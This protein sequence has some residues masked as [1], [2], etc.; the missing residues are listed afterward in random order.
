MPLPNAVAPFVETSSNM[1][2]FTGRPIIPENKKKNLF[3]EY[4]YDEKSSQISRFIA[5]KLN[6]LLRSFNIEGPAP[7][8]MDYFL[9]S[10]TGGL[11]RNLLSLSNAII[12]TVD[13]DQRVL[14]VWSSD[15]IKNVN[16]IPI[17]KAF[18]V[19]NPQLSSQFVT[20]F[21]E[22]LE[23]S[24]KTAGTLSK[25]EKEG[26]REKILEFIQSPEYLM[27]QDLTKT[28]QSISEFKEL[29]QLIRV[30]EEISPDEKRD[31]I[32]KLM[33]AIL[34]VSQGANRLASEY[35][36]RIKELEK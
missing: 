18:F 11:G 22:N 4:L 2:W 24:R 36:K 31:L 34:Q 10:W 32:D 33:V 5:G 13:T 21:Y 20:D 28:A 27:Y 15:W 6:P 30:H 7:I 14:N 17:V 1:S 35:R 19:R 26:N 8:N 3:S 25:L 12:K 29:I 16:D 23:R 9:T